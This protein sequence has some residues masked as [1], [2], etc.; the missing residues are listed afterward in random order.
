M[1]ARMLEADGAPETRAFCHYASTF[2]SV[3]RIPIG[4]QMT[5]TNGRAPSYMY[6]HAGGLRQRDDGRGGERLRGVRRAHDRRH[7][8]REPPPP[9][10]EL[11]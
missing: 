11:L 2:S 3:W 6:R 5:V 10:Y 4:K 7:L 8:K 1:E 9:P